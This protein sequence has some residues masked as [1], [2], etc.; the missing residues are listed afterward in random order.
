MNYRH[1]FHAGN[2]ADVLK[3]VALV[4]AVDHM[5]LK[6]KPFFVLDT[7]AGAGR[8]D[9]S[10][11]EALRSGEFRHG[12]ARILSDS[13][14]P[15]VLTPYAEA[16]R[17]WNLPGALVTYPGSPLL[18]AGRLRADDRLVACELHPGQAQLLGAAL[19]PFPQARVETR[20]GYAA[21]KALLPPP[22]RRGLVLIDPPFEQ[23]SEFAALTTHLLVACR[24]WSTGL[25]LVWYPIKDRRAVDMLH[26]AVVDAGLRDATA[27]ELFVRAPSGDPGLAGSGLLAINASYPLDRILGEALPYLADRL[28]QGRGAAWCSERLTPE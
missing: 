25:F 17:A 11:A 13:R 16:V 5:L 26:G 3:H 22:Q 2:H 8:Y 20:D 21:A 23:P 9:L 27:Y 1:A 18:I 7:H 4:A 19:R 15:A 28:A 12:A 10:S 6:S 14:L 24:R